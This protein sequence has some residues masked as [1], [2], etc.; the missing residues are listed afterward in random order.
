MVI[1][2]K[3]Y[4]GAVEVEISERPQTQVYC[5]CQSCRSWTG[6]QFLTGAV[7]SSDAVRF[8]GGEGNVRR[9][10]ITETRP[11]ERLSCAQCG[12]SIGTCVPALNFYDICVGILQ[13]FEFTPSIH[14]NYQ[15]RV[16]SMPDG[17][18]K[19]RDLPES[20]GGTGE[21]MEE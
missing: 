10:K 5:H 13:D 20:A 18:P 16:V 14:T 7:F 9:F 19:F 4:C 17:L 1:L 12:A 6:Q 8:V 11:V 2:G 15:D 3:C 21:M